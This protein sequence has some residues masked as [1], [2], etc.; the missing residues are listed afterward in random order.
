MGNLLGVGGASARAVGVGALAVVLVA[1]ACA[2]GGAGG[3]AAGTDGAP[4][5]A[6]QAAQMAQP[7]QMGPTAPA[8]SVPAAAPAAKALLRE[9]APAR[10][11]Q[12]PPE[13]AEQ[14][15]ARLEALWA[16]LGLQ[17]VAVPAGEFTMQAPGAKEKPRVE[18]VTAFLLARDEVTVGQFRQFVEATGYRTAAEADGGCRQ[19]AGDHWETGRGATWRSPGFPQGDDHPVVCV[20]WADVKAF[21]DWAGVRLPSEVEWEYAAGW[22][23]PRTAYSWGDGRPEG[24]LS[25]N[26]ASEEA[27]R[28]LG[29]SWAGQGIS[30]GHDDGYVYTAPVGSY[31]PNRLGLRDMTGNVL[32]WTSTRWKVSP[33]PGTGNAFAVRGGSWQSIASNAQVASASCYYWYNKSDFVGFRVARDAP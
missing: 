29:L 18:R 8:A 33:S 5:T 9:A 12:P 10:P 7:A 4:R 14:R 19:I 16:R 1:G 20:S 23:E 6:R 11:T 21:C 13:S 32:E 24:R 31:E 28:V 27:R 25:G 26:L 22:G 15:Q 30:F 3:A 17:F 2:H